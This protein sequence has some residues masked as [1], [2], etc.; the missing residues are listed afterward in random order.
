MALQPDTEQTA[1]IDSL[2]KFARNEL[3]DGVEEADRSREFPWESWH[4]C[5]GMQIQALPFPVEYG[6]C[7]ADFSTTVLS[8][9]A[10]GYACKDAG[11]VHAI[12]TQLLCGIQLREFG[13][14]ELKARYLPDLCSGNRVFCQA[15]TEPGSGSDAMAMRTRAVRDDDTFTLDGSKTFITNGPIADVALVFA[16]TNPDVKR[17]MGVSCFA[18]EQGTPGFERCPPLQKMGLNTL[19]NGELVLDG[20]RVS[21]DRI[22]GRVGQGAILFHESMEW[23]RI[24]LPAAHLGTLRRVLE[25][26]V[27]YAKQREAFGQPIGQ[28]QLVSE[29]IAA[30][31]VNLELGELALTRAAQLKDAGK[32]APLEAAICKLFVSESLKQ[33]CLDAVQIHGGYGYMAE[34]EVERD[35]RDSI[36]STVYSGTSELQKTIIAKLIGL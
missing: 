19:Q 25:T 27:E 13:S 24:L 12:A 14:D 15:I 26:T 1:L 4:K 5:A 28:F 7:G 11:L 10:L 34:Y 9:N 35:L 18:V 2:V 17:L 32:R 20:C 33:G 36:A 30:M 6:G 8:L 22:V 16:V 21:A 31:K 29:K 3:N 23:E